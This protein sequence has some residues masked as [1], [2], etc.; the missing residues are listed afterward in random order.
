MRL[1]IA[2]ISQEKRVL[3]LNWTMKKLMIRL[4]LFDMLQSRNFNPKVISWIKQIVTGG[5]IKIMI[6]GEDCLF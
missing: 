2:L 3:F 5:S 6:N 1:F 4:V